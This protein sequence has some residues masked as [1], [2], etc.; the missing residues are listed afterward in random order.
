MGA[1]EVH[2]LDSREM[3]PVET[4]SCALVLTSPPYFPADVE[5]VLRSGRVRDVGGLADRVQV[6]VEGLAPVFR[7]MAR[8]LR[9]GG[10]IALITRYLSAGGVQIPVTGW[11]RLLMAREGFVVGSRFFLRRHSRRSPGQRAGD[12]LR[13]G[14]AR[15]VGVEDVMVYR[16]ADRSG[17]GPRLERDGVT[18]EEVTAWLEPLWNLPSPGA[19]RRHPHQ[20]PREAGRRLMLLYSRPGDMVLD[21]FAGAAGLL[22]DGPAL[23]RRVIACELDPRYAAICRQQFKRVSQTRRTS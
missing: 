19:G 6:F 15:P 17:G 4:G 2:C 12:F 3:H 5:V 14:E 22:L 23:G 10:C 18:A 21:P 13:G 11:F 9:P 7:E 20:M 1:W 16:R 8:V